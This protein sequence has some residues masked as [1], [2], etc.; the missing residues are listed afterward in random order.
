LYESRCQK[1][2]AR[3]G[4]FTTSVESQPRLRTCRER[5]EERKERNGW[6]GI[7][8]GGKHQS[9]SRR[10]ATWRRGFGD[11]SFPPINLPPH[12]REQIRSGV[13]VFD[14]GLIY[15]AFVTCLVAVRG[16]SCSLVCLR[17]DYR[18]SE[19]ETKKATSRERLLNAWPQG[20]T[21]NGGIGRTSEL[22]LLSFTCF[23]CLLSYMYSR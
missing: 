1:E 15:I 22:L 19:A 12:L 2:R 16:Q 8:Q 21:E 3:V 13:S 9:H 23:V 20:K 17:N 18:Q 4:E 14:L 11:V 10:G 7:E 6:L 5:C